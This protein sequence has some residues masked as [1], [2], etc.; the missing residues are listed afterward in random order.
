MD[1]IQQL[2][3]D[4]SSNPASTSSNHKLTIDLPETRG[5]KTHAREESFKKLPDEKG[6]PKKKVVRYKPAYIKNKKP[7]KLFFLN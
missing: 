6:G 3:E 2:Q 1:G 5:T 4:M 7:K